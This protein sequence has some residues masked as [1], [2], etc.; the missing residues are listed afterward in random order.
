MKT[1][2]IINVLNLSDYNQNSCVGVALIQFQK[3]YK[4]YLQQVIINLFICSN[5]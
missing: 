3:R 5:L 4:L 1:A 2:I